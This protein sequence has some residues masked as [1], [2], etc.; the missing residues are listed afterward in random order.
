MNYFYIFILSILSSALYANELL[1]IEPSLEPITDQVVQQSKMSAMT[2]EELSEVQGQ[3]LYSLGRQEQDGLSFYTL[4]MEA[5]IALNA[6]IKSL[7]L[8]CGGI[9]GAGSCDIDASN[10]SFGCIANGSGTCITLPK[11]NSR[12]PNG[13]V[14][15]TAS[16]V[17]PTQ[18]QMK[19]FNLTNPF[20]QFA[21]KDADKASTREVL[22][23]RIGA[24][25]AK[26]PL[27]FGDLS[28][29][30]GYLTGKANLVTQAQ[31]QVG[32]TS[33]SVSRYKGLDAYLG[34]SDG[35]VLDINVIL[36]RGTVKYRDVSANYG[37]ISRNNLDVV[38]TGNRIKQAKISGLQFGGIVDEVMQ[39]L[40][41]ADVNVNVCALILCT[42]ITLGSG[43]LDSVKGAILNILRTQVTNKIKLDLANGLSGTN[44]SGSSSTDI[45]N[46]LQAYQLP[47]NLNNVHQLDVD[48]KSFGIALSKQAIKYPGY[49]SSVNRGWSMYLQNAFTLNINDKLSNLVNNIASQP[50]ARNGNITMLQSSYRNCYGSLTFC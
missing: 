47:F 3:A 50:D 2:D 17:Q 20:F 38:V 11:T 19:D 18:S 25:E 42:D 26:G 39:S 12:Q 24:A 14:Q 30:S 29:F 35:T 37:G 8:G 36:G 32:V 5:N 44:M 33:E 31:N 7:Q 21:I 41:L 45:H 15:E 40:A 23:V 27:S 43:S 22:G 34:L 10:V 13:T 49:A 9:N 6:N 4:S 48:S 1:P 28:S 46:W 16:G